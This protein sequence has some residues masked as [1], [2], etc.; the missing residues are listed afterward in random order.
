MVIKPGDNVEFEISPEH[1]V[2]GTVTDVAEYPADM[3]DDDYNLCTI[4]EEDTGT[5]W[6]VSK[7]RIKGIVDKSR[8]EISD[9]DRAMRGVDGFYH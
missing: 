5:I 3:V 4:E 1:T 7:D 9:Y 2:E 8:N 6:T